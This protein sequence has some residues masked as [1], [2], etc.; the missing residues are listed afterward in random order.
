MWNI[1]HPDKIKLSEYE[2]YDLVFVASEN[3]AT[4]LQGKIR[5]PVYPLLQCTDPE[6]FFVEKEL[7][8]NRKDIIFVGNTRRIKRPSVIWA[9]QLDLPIKVWGMG[10]E[11][12]LEQKYIKGSYYQNQNLR[13]LYSSAKATLN[14]HYIDMQEKGFI[15][16]LVYDA[17]ACG[18]PIISKYNRVLYDLFP[19]EILYY[20]NKNEFLECV[21]KVLYSYSDIKKNVNQVVPI[22]QKEHSFERRVEFMLKKFSKHMDRS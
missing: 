5:T 8:N 14:D 22:I 12:W 10:W 2:T 21:N 16:N 17:L 3:Y 15:N 18:L 20:K 11:K 7:D 4:Y 19:K 13:K 1:S 6:E 9:L